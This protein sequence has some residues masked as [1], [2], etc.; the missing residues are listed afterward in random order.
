[1]E[2]YLYT[3]K[4]AKPHRI[5]KI[6]FPRSYLSYQHKLRKIVHNNQIVVHLQLHGRTRKWLNND[7][8]RAA[9]TI[10]STKFSTFYSR[11][12]AVILHVDG[13]PPAF[14]TLRLP[15]RIPAPAISMST[16]NSQLCTPTSPPRVQTR[17]SK[18]PQWASRLQKTNTQLAYSKL[19][20][21]HLPHSTTSA[22]TH[23]LST[24]AP[25]INPIRTLKPSTMNSN[26]DNPRKQSTNFEERTLCPGRAGCEWGRNEEREA[27]GGRRS[28]MAAQ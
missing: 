14:C 11:I 26:H 12:D 15:L 2:D 25:L 4:V 24:W 19:R 22:A 7:K 16:S 17:Q 8:A 13:A 20:F 28:E 21:P 23:S 10:T 5:T 9:Y 27:R 6:C 18:P 1:M 3:S